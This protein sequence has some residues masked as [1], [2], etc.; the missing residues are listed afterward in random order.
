MTE[1]PRSAYREMAELLL[2]ARDTLLE[3]IG[4]HVPGDARYSF[5]MVAN[6][7]AIAARALQAGDG[8]VR[9]ALERL[10][11]LYGEDAVLPDAWPHAR[12]EALERRLAQDIRAGTY[13]AGP[14]REQVQAYLEAR[15]R[16]E[17]AV[18]NPRYLE[19]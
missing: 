4:P 3:E 2:T 1:E 14:A 15:A 5:L 19:R 18:S 6:A 13:D 8:P 7:L 11:G 10:R 16:D 9:D 17:V 12:I